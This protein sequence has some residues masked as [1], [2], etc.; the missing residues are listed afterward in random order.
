MMHG[1]SLFDA[2]SRNKDANDSRKLSLGVA[3]S[4]SGAIDERSHLLPIRFALLAALATLVATPFAGAT[5]AIAPGDLD[6]P[7]DPPRRLALARG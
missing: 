5:T 4:S 7:L 1:D 3:L 2:A 6:Q